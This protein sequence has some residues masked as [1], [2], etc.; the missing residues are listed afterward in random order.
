MKLC[1]NCGSQNA[2]QYTQCPNCGAVLPAAAPQPTYS[3]AA[4]YVPPAYQPQRVTSMGAWFGWS[5]LCAILPIIGPIIMIFA[6]NEPS[7]KNF[8]KAMTVFQIVFGAIGAAS[9]AALV[10]TLRSLAGM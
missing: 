7:A 5:L 6:A 2:D 1:P 8:G 10:A 4:G 9:S 3:G